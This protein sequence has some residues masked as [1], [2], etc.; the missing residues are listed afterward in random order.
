MFKMNQQLGLA[1]ARRAEILPDDKGSGLTL[2]A[3]KILLGCVF[4]ATLQAYDEIVSSVR[5]SFV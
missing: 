1:T 5:E 2:T 4:S 3:G